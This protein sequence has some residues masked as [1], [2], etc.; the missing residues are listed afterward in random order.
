MKLASLHWGSIFLVAL[1]AAGCSGGTGPAGPQGP[2]GQPGPPGPPG[3]GSASITIP[4]NATPASDA[5]AAAWAALD[6]RVTVTSVSINS[7]PVFNFTVTDADGVPV[8]G[9]GNTSMSSTATVPSLTN[10]SFSVAKLV[11]GTDGR[12]SE[13]I[14]YM[15]TTV[16]TTTSAV[17]PS[18]PTTDSAGTLV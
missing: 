9:L 15:V 12:P 5:D 6:L 3:S 1:M 17:A 14:S 18:R 2:P 4:S 10:L 8:T 11:P 13:W 16:P 7:P